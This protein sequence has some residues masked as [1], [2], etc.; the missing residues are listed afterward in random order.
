MRQLYDIRRGSRHGLGDQLM[1][2]PLAKL[3]NADMLAIVAYV[4][5]LPP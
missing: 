5:S 2:Q 4:A 1:G 3:S